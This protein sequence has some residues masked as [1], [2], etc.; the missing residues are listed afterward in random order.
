[1]PLSGLKF[2]GKKLSFW[3]PRTFV[4]A[5]ALSLLIPAPDFISGMSDDAFAVW[6]IRIGWVIGLPLVF[7][8]MLVLI[9]LT[10]KQAVKGRPQ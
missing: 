6:L 9:A 2:F 1:M 3:L 5:F 10:G 7:C 4:V 8:F